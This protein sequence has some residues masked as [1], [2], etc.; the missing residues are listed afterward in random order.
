MRLVRHP[1]VIQDIVEIADFIAQENLDASDRFIA[2]TEETFAHLLKMP[3]LGGVREFTN[4]KLSAVRM[5]R[6][7]GFEKYL[8]FYQATTTEVTILRVLH[9]ARDI[10]ELFN[11][12]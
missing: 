4:P 10:E 2:A 11:D 5:W 7:K 3:E 9:G 12:E 6:L 8:V 1:Q